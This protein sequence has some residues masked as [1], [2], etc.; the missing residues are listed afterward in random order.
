MPRQTISGPLIGIAIALFY[1]GIVMQVMRNA[2]A[3]IGPDLMRDV[4]FAPSGL[5]VL[6]GVYFYAVAISQ[7]P[8]GIML[9]RIGPKRTLTV[10]ALISV[11][12]AL[13]FA[14]AD[15]LLGLS[16]GRVLLAIGSAPT[17]IGGFLVFGRWL[18]PDA[19]TR[20]SA[21]HVSV[22][23]IGSVLATA[24]FAY[25][26][27]QIGWRGNFYLAAAAFVLS[28]A[29]YGLVV[30][31]RPPEARA[32]PPTEGESLTESL[33]AVLR[34]FG[35]HSFYKVAGMTFFGYPVVATVLVLVAGPYLHDVHGF[36]QVER[37][38]ALFA[39]GILI[40][41]APA[42]CSQFTRWYSVRA[43]SLAMAV[44]AIA[45]LTVLA[46]VPGLPLA[47]VAV[48]FG[49]LGGLG[50]YAV[51]LITSGRAM[52]GEKLAARA[53]T[54]LNLAQMT[55]MGSLQLAVGAIIAAFPAHDGVYP[56]IAYRTAFGFLAVGLA[57]ASLYYASGGPTI[58][59]NTRASL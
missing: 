13:T 48:L 14:M 16:I 39:M 21:M 17:V 9:D 38:N 44:A 33:L 53:L 54:A 43:V 47:A 31:D 1:G 25:L 18:A 55:G 24:P 26:A 46:A 35:N 20:A 32:A 56:E 15:S 49:L 41:A 7:I 10:A 6:T 52:F 11:A 27:A 45:V 5:G 3:T 40:A 36:D 37:G 19:F 34:I 50:A 2:P 23:L 8:L 28:A 42:A 29:L 12:G 30:R 58:A 51:L 22:G 59:K 57:A 4:G